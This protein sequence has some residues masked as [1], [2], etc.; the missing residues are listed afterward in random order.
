MREAEA[1]ILDESAGGTHLVIASRYPKGAAYRGA[2]GFDYHEASYIVSGAATRAFD[3][4]N[5]H[6]LKPGDLIF[7]R[8]VITQEVVYEPG[9]INVA[10][11][12]STR[13]RLLDL[14]RG[15]TRRGIEQ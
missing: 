3:G 14:A 2:P 13:D 9:P 11:F 6:R 1:V 7:V 15:L 10:F 8:Q 5:A 12:R 4:S